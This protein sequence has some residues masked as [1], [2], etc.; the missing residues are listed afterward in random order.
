[1]DDVLTPQEVAEWLKVDETTLA[2]WRAQGAGPRFFKY[3]DADQSPVR[4]TREAVD[5]FVR[6][7]ID[8]ASP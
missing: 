1:M 5:E 8:K 2:R 6:G 3:G 7:R 4:Y